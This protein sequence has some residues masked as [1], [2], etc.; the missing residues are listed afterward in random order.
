MGLI[1]ED[2]IL[3]H[4]GQIIIYLVAFKALTVGSDFSIPMWLKYRKVYTEWYDN[5]P[6]FKKPD[7]N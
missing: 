4:L 3:Y 6:K 1:M 2:S 5:R 7:G